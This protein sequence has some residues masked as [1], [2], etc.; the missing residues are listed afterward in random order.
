MTSPINMLHGF[1]EPSPPAWTPQTVGWYCMFAVIAIAAIWILVCAIHRWM[2]NRYRRAALKE[3]E[4]L[5]VVDF[6]VLLKRTALSVWPREKVA[7]L[8]GAEW[9][10]F[11]DNKLRGGGFLVTPGNQIENM[12]FGEANLSA[13]DEKRLRELTAKWIRSHRVRA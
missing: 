9:L 3:L 5:T 10:Q 11:L 2:F 12:A 8:S 7:S 1:Y 6:S 4:T 13:E